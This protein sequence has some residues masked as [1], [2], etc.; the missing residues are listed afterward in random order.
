MARVREGSSR[1]AAGRPANGNPE[2]RITVRCPNRNCNTIYRVRAR[3]AGRRARC[4]ECGTRTLIPTTRVSVVENTPAP[5]RRTKPAAKAGVARSRTRR[6]VRI[7]AIGRGHA[8]KTALFQVLGESLVGDFLPSGLHLDAGD[9]R[10]VARMIRESEAAQRLLTAVRPAPNA[11][12]FADAL[13]HLRRGQAA[14]RLPDARGDRPDSD[15]HDA[16]VRTA[17]AG[18]IRG[19][20]QEPHQRQRPVGGGTLPAGRSSG[21]ATAAA[22]PTTSGSQWPIFAR[23]CGCG[24]SRNRPRWD[25][26]SARPMRS[27]RPPRRLAPRSPTTCWLARSGR[28]CT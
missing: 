18:A 16:R 11:A 23:R 2:A 14:D 20:H 24:L 9:P 25:S 4:A 21:R 10:E 5:E 12:R 26:C 19:L 6:E 3:H 13:L 28:S 1:S 27:S 15:A 22:T 8:G 7:G 17:T